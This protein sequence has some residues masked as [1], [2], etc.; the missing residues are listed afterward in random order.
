MELYIKNLLMQLITGLNIYGY[1]SVALSSF[2]EGVSI[3]FPSLIILLLAGFLTSQGKL[4]IY[5]VIFIAAASYTI[6]SSIPYFIGY[7]INKG[8]LNRI[9]KYIKISD[10]H[11]NEIN[12]MFNKYGEKAV[13][14][15][16]PVLI[17]NYISYFAGINRMPLIRFYIYTFLG[18][19]PWA[20]LIVFIGSKFGSSYKL[21]YS[22]IGKYMAYFNLALLAAA[23]LFV[24]IKRKE[25]LKVIMKFKKRI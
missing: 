4:N 5:F 20:A 19:F 9:K 2:M 25:V 16:R 11:I 12:A 8:L 1:S 17:G 10:K 18:I 3:P 24:F 23:V 22:V 21:A 13:C 14:F 7:F 15:T 6:G